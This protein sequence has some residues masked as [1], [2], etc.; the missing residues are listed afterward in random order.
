[1]IQKE[2]QLREVTIKIAVVD[3]DDNCRSDIKK[4][5]ENALEKQ[6]VDYV[7]SLYA[8]PME[9]IIDL[10]N[11]AYYSVFLIDVEMPGMSG[12]EL[13][14]KVQE[15]YTDVVIIFITDY[16]KYSPGA[17][18]VNAFRYILKKD[19]SEKLPLAFQKILPRI[20]EQEKGCYI[21]RHYLDAD[22]LL[23][24]EI[25]YIKKEGKNAVF[26]H[27]NGNSYERKSLKKII[28][29]LP[30]KQFIEVGRGYIVNVSCVKGLR[31][32]E[33][34]LQN[35]DKIPVGRGSVETLI[36]RIAE[37]WNSKK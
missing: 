37:Y 7:I 13:A 29:E 18:E 10:E 35:G 34:I 3:D 22:V 5:A 2:E 32:K 36:E 27:A 8:S 21:V 26:V 1:M 16:V 12:L 25:Y 28:E 15:F 4:I 23:Y 24:R 6:N 9:L 31:D 33:I 30:E 11:K 20:T 14:K 17:F 19:L